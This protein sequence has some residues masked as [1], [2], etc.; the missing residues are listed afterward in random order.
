M[1]ETFAHLFHYSKGD[2]LETTVISMSYMSY[3]SHMISYDVNKEHWEQK[4]N[5]HGGVDRNPAAPGLKARRGL[6]LEIVVPR[7]KTR[8]SDV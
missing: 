3:I 8:A 1:I 4:K 5:V 2:V 6:R 7:G